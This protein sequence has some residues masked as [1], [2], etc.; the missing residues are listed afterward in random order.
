MAFLPVS[1][2]DM[3]ERGWEEVDVVVVTGDAYV[4]HP[5]FGT[6]IIS[7]LLERFGYRVAV[8]AQPDWR[9]CDDFRR[10]GRPRLGFV[11]GSGSVDSM[12]DNYSVFK[13]KRK[14]D[15]YS[16]GGK[17]GNR[18]DRAV[19]VY[20]NRAREAYKDVPIIIGGLEAS[21]RR[22][23]H[24]DYWDDRIRRSILLDSRADL[25]V[26]GMGERANIEICEALA[27]G[28]DVK[29]IHWIRGTA[30]ISRSLPDD[31]DLICLPDFDEV[32]CS[33]DAS[34]E[35]IERSK[36]KYADSFIIQHENNDSINGC[37]LAEKYDEH[38]YVV[39]NPPQDPLSREEL[40]DLYAM[41]FERN[42][43][44]MYEADGGVPAISEVKFSITANRGCFG[45]C[46]F[47]AIT[48]H[49]GRQVRSRSKES[50]LN[51]ARLLTELPDY[52]GYI[53]DVGGPTANFHAPACQEQLKRGV[54]KKKDCLWPRPCSKM[55]IS[56]GEYLDVLRSVRELDK[57]KKV[58]IR[59]GVRYDY[60]M[61]DKD[62]SFIRELCEHH[63]SGTLK[64]AP[65]HICGGVLDLMRKPGISVFEQFKDEFEKCNKR[66]GKEQYMIPYLISSHPGATLDDA[67]DMAL[68]L[69][70]MHFVPDQVQDFYP[71]PGTMS[72]CMYYTEMDPYTKKK[73]YVAKDMREKKMQ[74]ALLHFNKRENR[75]TVLA[76][77][78]KA[79][80]EDDARYLLDDRGHSGHNRQS[81]QKRNKQKNRQGG[82]K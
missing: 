68:Y 69:K 31:P 3:A 48:L 36:R 29:D 32:S 60:A 25:L 21:L 67:V 53:H 45:G 26:Y 24:Y 10:F 65:E 63:V 61:A 41:D 18:P 28:I 56:H 75:E 76:A 51:E 15:V 82:R 27:A 8:L 2:E 22:F 57:V 73:I 13:R 34:H 70:K 62:H 5:S 77:L 78:K 14:R 1:K 42:Y 79:G 81:R 37:M 11:I 33:P 4:D 64:V 44:P 39:Q 59:S 66:I 12:V 72:T 30:Y 71:T 9:S 52:K 43:H 17:A 54:C 35:D 23:S 38:I 58:F 49:Q 6:A 47:C 19:T 7:R 20:C 74:R 50:I 46:S 40:D 80:R 16:P 55:D